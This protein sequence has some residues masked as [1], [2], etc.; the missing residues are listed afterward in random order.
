MSYEE[1]TWDISIIANFTKTNIAENNIEEKLFLK[2]EL[3][4]FKERLELY[5]V[6][7]YE[8]IKQR[9]SRDEDWQDG[10]Y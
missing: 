2:E 10:Y 3:N 6:E 5:G 8:N 7:V 9:E 1:N 4:I